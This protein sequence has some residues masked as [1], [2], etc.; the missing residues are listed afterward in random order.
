MKKAFIFLVILS[1]PFSLTAD[2]S[3]LRVVYGNLDFY[4]PNNPLLIGYLGTDS[5]ILIA[6]Y[7]VEP[8]KDIVGFSLDKEVNTG[9]CS[10]EVFFRSVLGENEAECDI[11]AIDSFRYVFMRN[12]DSGVWSGSDKDFFYFIGPDKSTVFMTKN[13]NDN[14][15]FKIESNFLSKEK[16]KNIFSS[17]L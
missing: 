14:E 12:R 5:E 6:K 8:G 3:R 11:R 10:P 1:F 16:I 17:H 2:D 4:V 15:T 7:S 9:G 13:D